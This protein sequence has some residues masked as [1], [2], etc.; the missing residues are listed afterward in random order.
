MS[1]SKTSR[2]SCTACDAKLILKTGIMTVVVLIAAHLLNDP[3][4]VCALLERTQAKSVKLEPADKA[5]ISDLTKVT[6]RLSRELGCQS[7]S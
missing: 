6:E 2:Q 1:A 5:S 3:P 4:D 7:T